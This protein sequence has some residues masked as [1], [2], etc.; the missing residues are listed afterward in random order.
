[1]KFKSF[2]LRL[3]GR[4]RRHVKR[5]YGMKSESLIFLNAAAAYKI[6]I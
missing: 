2:K 6:A 3:R 1:L 5:P 4:E